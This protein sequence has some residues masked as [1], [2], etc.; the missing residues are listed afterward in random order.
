MS[1]LDLSASM[2]AHCLASNAVDLNLK[3]MKWRLQPNIDLDIIKSKKVLLLGSGTLGCNVARVLI[4]WGCSWITFVDNGTVSFS[5]PVRQSLFT[6]DDSV[7]KR[8]KSEAAANAI[9]LIAPMVQTESATSR[10]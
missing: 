5:N 2:D 4:G 1:H 9:K 3:L 10:V 6:F 8:N 7:K